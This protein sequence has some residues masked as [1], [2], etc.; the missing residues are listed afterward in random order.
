MFGE[1]GGRGDAQQ[2]APVG[3]LGDL[4]RGLLLEAQ[5]F[6]R[7]AGK[8]QRRLAPSPSEPPPNRP[9]VEPVS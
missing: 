5:D 2:P 4:D 7:A 8:A 1:R 6:D 3:G 9:E